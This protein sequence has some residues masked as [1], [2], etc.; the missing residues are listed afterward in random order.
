MAG[1]FDSVL[2]AFFIGKGNFAIPVRSVLMV[3][4][5]NESDLSDFYA[6]RRGFQSTPKP[7]T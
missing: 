6:L 2:C 4:L 5:V 3:E 7:S 1:F